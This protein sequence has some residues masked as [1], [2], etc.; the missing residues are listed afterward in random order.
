MRRRLYN[1]VAAI[2]LTL[3]AVSAGAV[4][5]SYFRAWGGCYRQSMREDICVISRGEFAYTLHRALTPDAAHPYPLGWFAS[6]EQ[7]AFDQ[8]ERLA[9][10]GGASWVGFG[11]LHRTIRFGAGSMTR[12]D[13]LMVPGWCIIALFAVLPLWRVILRRVER[14]KGDRLRRGACPT[15]GY[16]LRATPGRCPE[17][18]T[19]PQLPHNPPMQRTGAAGIVICRRNAAE[20]QLR[21]PIGLTLCHT[22]SQPRTTCD[23]CGE[24]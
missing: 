19:V 18:G 13:T 7:P 8:P 17:C 15:C 20:A 12:Y 5:A 4:V 16:D 23:A 11:T 6:A 1:L 14:A 22:A 2:S 10:A 24:S 9:R 21:P 3:C